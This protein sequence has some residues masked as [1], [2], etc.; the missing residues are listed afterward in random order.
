MYLA[1]IGLAIF[2][3]GVTIVENNKIEKELIMKTGDTVMI[4][5]YIFEFETFFKED[6]PNYES[7]KGKFNVFKD[8]KLISILNPEK[9]LYFSNKSDMPMTE[10]GIDPS[11]SRD[12]YISLGNLVDDNS[13]SVRI[14]YKPLVRFIW[15]GALIMVLG[16]LLSICFQMSLNR[17]KT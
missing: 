15:L 14:Y 16:A 7:L 9:R 11:F 12:L 2:T 4:N 17:K 8:G 3:L 6:G 13:W 1:H 10:A 5:Q